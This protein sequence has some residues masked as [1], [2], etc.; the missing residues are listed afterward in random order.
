MSTTNGTEANNPLSADIRQLG[1]LLGGIIKEQQGEAAFQLV[2]EVRASAKARR[3]GDSTEQL[4]AL[5]DQTTLDQ[6]RTLIKAFSNYF[7]LI[8]IAEDQQRIRALRDRERESEQSGTPVSE[9]ISEAVHRLCASGVTADQMRALLEKTRVRL[10]MTAHPSEA[11]RKEVLIKLRDIADMMALLE[12]KTLL[13]REQKHYHAAITRRIEQLWQI[14]PTRA[15]QAKVADE[16]DFGLY[17]LTSVV[18]EVVVMLYEELQTEL[19]KCYPGEDWS[20]LPPILRFASWTPCAHCAA[21]P[22]RFISA[23]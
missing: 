11:K 20:T 21:P 3:G 17:F 23:T 1:N 8:N 19:E 22:N 12:D 5:I 7:Q 6:K 16:V 10:V 2:E 15:A 18:M 9:T 13:Q 4:A 14:Q